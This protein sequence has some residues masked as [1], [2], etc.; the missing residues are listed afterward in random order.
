[1]PVYM[2][3]APDMNEINVKG[4]LTVEASWI[5]SFVMFVMYG[6]IM[7]AFIL[8]QGTN[9]YV[10]GLSEKGIDSVALFRRTAMIYDFIK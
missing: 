5:F 9:E 3:R 7:L 2:E 4:V 1:M 10:L 8:Y 6:V